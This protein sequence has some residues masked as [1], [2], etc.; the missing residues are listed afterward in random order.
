VE[1]EALLR[2][3]TICGNSSYGAPS[4]PLRQA[5]GRYA[6][7]SLQDRLRKCGRKVGASF[8]GAVVFQHL[9]FTSSSCKVL[10]QVHTKSPL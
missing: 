1:T 8:E 9:F 5:A 10:N 3:L 2:P 4:P 6:K 7:C